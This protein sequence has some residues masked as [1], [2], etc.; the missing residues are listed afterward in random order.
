MTDQ[1]KKTVS[2]WL[3][4]LSIIIVGLVVFG[5]YVRLTRSGLSI[6]E[7][8]VFTGVIPPIG[9]EAWMEEKR[10]IR[11]M[12]QGILQ[13]GLA[14]YQIEQGSWAGA[15]KMFGRGLPKL[16]Q[17]PDVCQG[18]MIGEFRRQADTVRAEIARLGANGLPGFDTSHLPQIGFE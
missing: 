8:N 2:R 7:W 11:D 10:P 14:F 5:G 3:Y 1:A 13:V 4:I 18:V 6:V 16:R 17:L 9:E 12:Y 15:M